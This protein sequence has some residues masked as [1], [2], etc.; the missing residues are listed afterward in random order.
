MKIL[1]RFMRFLFGLQAL[2]LVIVI[3]A[4]FWLPRVFQNAQLE[5]DAQDRAF[6]FMVMLVA[7]CIWDAVPAIAWWKLRKGRREARWWA[8]AA[9]ALCLPLPLPGIPDYALRI[10][11]SWTVFAIFLHVP[12]QLVELAVGITG[13]AVFLRPEASGRTIAEPKLEPVQGDGTSKYWEY[14]LQAFVSAVTISALIWWP[15]WAASHSLEVPNFPVVLAIVFLAIFIEI[16]GHELGHFAAGTLC[17]KKLRIF[18]VGPFQWSVR[19]GKWKFEFSPKLVLSGSVGMVPPT[20]DNFRRRK[21]IGLVGGPVAS[22]TMS[23]LSLV[24]LL[25]VKNTSWRFSWFLLAM[26]TTVSSLSFVANL[27]PQRTKLFYS[28]GAQ[29]YQILSNGPWGKVHLALGMVTTSLVTTIRPRDWDIKLISEAADFLKTGT[30]A[31]LLRLF[32]S[33]YYLESGNISEALANV[34]AAES[35]FGPESVSN[36]AD[37]YASFVFVNALYARDL[38]AAEKW[39]QKLQSLDRIDYD[40]DYWCARSSIL[41]LSGELEDAR[42]AWERGNERAQK[43]PSSGIYD[44]TRWQ[45]AELRKVLD[46]GVPGPSPRTEDPVGVT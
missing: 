26:I 7:I 16:C 41:W 35:L 8:V 12:R 39:W 11:H 19:N 3:P 40:A 31:M 32:A 10:A 25:N 21:V 4:F 44:F 1:G 27:I 22:L 30:K 28:D 29:L 6:Q 43:L 24:A 33:K 17:G 45:F 14:A 23:L 13:L 20:L 38:P 37:F 18:H 9:S 36:P 5:P 2:A 42:Q 46:Q 15:R 34:K